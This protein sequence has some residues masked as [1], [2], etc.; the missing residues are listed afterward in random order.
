[1]QGLHCLHALRSLKAAVSKIG[2]VQLPEKDWEAATEEV[3]G[4]LWQ[5]AVLLLAPPALMEGASNELLCGFQALA[6]DAKC[7][8][9]AVCNES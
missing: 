9:P 5:R 2:G 4:A 8:P 6:A 3:W 7:A 1:M